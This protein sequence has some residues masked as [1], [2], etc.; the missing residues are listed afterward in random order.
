MLGSRPHV[1]WGEME[2]RLARSLSDWVQF[3]RLSKERQRE[4]LAG[5]HGSELMINDILE[6]IPEQWMEQQNAEAPHWM[7]AFTRT[8]ILIAM[9]GCTST[10]SLFF[11]VGILGRL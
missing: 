4:C 3:M 2:A 8:E 5:M 10:T 9:R 1:S 6:A 7:G 11:D